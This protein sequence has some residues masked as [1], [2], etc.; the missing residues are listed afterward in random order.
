MPRRRDVRML[1]GPPMEVQRAPQHFSANRQTDAKLRV[2]QRLQCLSGVVA[3]LGAG[4][5]VVVVDQPR[6]DLRR[7]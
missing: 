4:A 3:V 6:Q 5:L 1:V 7:G 2:G